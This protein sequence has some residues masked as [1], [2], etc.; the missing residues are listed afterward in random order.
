MSDFENEEAKAKED[1]APVVA[2]EVLAQGGPVPLTQDQEN[3]LWNLQV[4]DS[5]DH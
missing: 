3:V 4:L 1:V 5:S 2:P